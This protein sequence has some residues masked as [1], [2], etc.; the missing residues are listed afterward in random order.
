MNGT[1]KQ[2]YFIESSY[3]ASGGPV[4]VFIGGEV[5]ID[6]Y[7]GIFQS[8]IFQD[9][10]QQYQ[11]IGII[12]ENRYYGE[13]YPFATSTTDELLY[14]TTEQTIADLNSFAKNVR[15]PGIENINAPKS[16]WILYGG[17]LAGALSAFT[18]KTYGNTY[19]A[20]I[21]SSG[22]IHAQVGYPQW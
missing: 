6:F 1:F 10:I 11:G 2:R 22:V 3:Y 18:M 8:S 19:Y 4:F 17:S 9:L 21:S 14:M 7:T 20:G 13:S 12:L 16:P 5:P 15:V